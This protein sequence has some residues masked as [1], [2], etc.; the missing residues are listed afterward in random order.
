MF[1]QLTPLLLHT[2]FQYIVR[3]HHQNVH[4]KCKSFLMILKIFILNDILAN[5]L[6]TCIC[7]LKNVK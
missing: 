1:I 5:W 2:V 3:H 6:N 4:C 7:V